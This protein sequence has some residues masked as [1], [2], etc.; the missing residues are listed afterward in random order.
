M[1]SG[2]TQATTNRPFSV[3]FAVPD[4]SVIVQ[5]L[6]LLVDY[7]EAR[8]TIPGSGAVTSVR[9][10]II[11][12]QAGALSSPFDL[13]TALREQIA[14]TAAP[15]TPGQLFTINFFDCLGA[16]PPT[17]ADFT[18]TVQLASDPLGQP[19]SGVTCSVSAA[20]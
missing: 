20:P 4:S 17:A 16:T 6:T 11:N 5:G 1:G 8:V 18:C 3:S 7:P 14:G 9:Q 12:V 10:A 19:D 15:M 2:C 13:D